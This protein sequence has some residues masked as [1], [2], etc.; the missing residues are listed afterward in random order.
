MLTSAC[1]VLPITMMLLGFGGA[2]LGVFAPIAAAGYYVAGASALL[3]AAA[4]I[5]AARRRLRGPALAV[6]G[7]GSALTGAAWAV[8]LNEAAITDW[9][10]GMM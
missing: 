4:W 5:V 1:C 7:L 10:I 8:L 9:L 6:L 3:L 2:W